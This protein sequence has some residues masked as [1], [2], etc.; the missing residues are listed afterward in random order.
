VVVE[1]PERL[2]VVL[3]PAAEAEAAADDDR[4]IA[5]RQVELVH[6]LRVQVRGQTLR[7]GPLPAEGQHVGG[8]VAAVDVEAGLQKRH[9]QPAGSARDVERRLPCLDEAL[10]VRDL[11]AGSVELRPPLRDEPVVPRLRLAHPCA[12]GYAPR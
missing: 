8:D 3:P 10:E 12:H 7:L 5:P 2:E 4:P 9:E 1:A 6:G 11:W